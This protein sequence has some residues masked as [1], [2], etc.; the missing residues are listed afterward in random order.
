MSALAARLKRYRR[1]AG[2][3]QQ[4]IADRLP[5]TQQT[6]HQWESGRTTPRGANLNRLAKVL[7]VSR[8]KLAD[9]GVADA[10]AKAR[11]IRILAPSEVP[12]SFKRSSAQD[13]APE[14]A[15]WITSPIPAGPL[16]FAVRILEPYLALLVTVDDVV[17]VDPERAP[18]HLDLVLARIGGKIHALQYHAVGRK[19]WLSGL[20]T[21]IPFRAPVSTSKI[22]GVI[23]A[24]VRVF[25]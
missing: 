15:Q 8:G 4:D 24:K 20:S 11:P 12:A 16:V 22:I 17:V 5:V 18:E 23:V 7:K 14:T 19:R 25:K 2:L 21:A 13:N 10:A 6:I 1:D 9:G 3:T